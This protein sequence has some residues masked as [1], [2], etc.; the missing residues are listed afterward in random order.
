MPATEI[1]L[2]VPL[3]WNAAST[4]RAS[5]AS[6]LGPDGTLNNVIVKVDVTSPHHDGGSKFRQARYVVD[7]S[8]EVWL[9]AAS[10]LRL[11]AVQ[12]FVLAENARS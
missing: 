4:A 8:D 6:L 5:L 2:T 1:P 7:S 10:G 12:A 3:E 9:D 11:Y